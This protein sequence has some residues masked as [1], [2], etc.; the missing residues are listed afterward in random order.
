M[1]NIINL[2]GKPFVWTLEI[3]RKLLQWLWP[4][5]DARLGPKLRNTEQ[6]HPKR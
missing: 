3:S 1:R 2:I 5:I 6:I 4:Q